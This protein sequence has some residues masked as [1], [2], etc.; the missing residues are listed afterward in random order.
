MNVL[1]NPISN[2]PQLKNSHVLGWSLVWANQLNASIDHKCSENILNTTTCYIEHG[3]NFG[4]TLN[5]FG[6]ATKDVFDRINRVAEHPNVVSL[7]FDM[8]DWGAQ[9]KKR[10]GAPTTYEGITEQWC[11]ALSNRLSLV[12]SLKQEHLL[13]I[14]N[15]FDGISVGDSH[16][17]AFSRSTDIVL[18]ENGKTLYGAL[19]RGLITEFRG[20]KPFGNI[21]FCYGSIDVRHHIL[22]HQNFNLD[23]MLH[24]YVKQ[25]RIIQKEYDCDIS[26]SAPVPVEYEER[27][28]P[29]T[30][31]YKGTPFY[32]SREQRLQLTLRFIDGLNKIGVNVVQPPLDWYKMDG[33]LYAKMFME[34]NSSVHI[35]PQ[36]YR[37]NNWSGNVLFK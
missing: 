19:K 10:I 21:T 15:K 11:D 29:K 4:G 35:S 24:E 13:D 12:K 23:D 5:L 20:L 36:Y 37:R 25:A 14:S 16:T 17:P 9:L 33:E 30:G 22:R 6:G 3:V 34:N 28:L 18:R 26:F 1:T 32:G 8:P 31:Y 27:K 7:D 2:I